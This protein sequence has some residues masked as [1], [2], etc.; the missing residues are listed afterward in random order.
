MRKLLL[1]SAFFAATSLQS[2]ATSRSTTVAF[3]TS[4]N[5]MGKGICS[6]GL[7]N[8]IPA[9]FTY[10]AGSNILTISFNDADLIKYEPGLEPT[11]QDQTSYTFDNAWTAPDVINTSLS[12]AKPI[13]I[14]AGVAYTLTYNGG[15]G[16]R[17]I[18]IDL[19][20]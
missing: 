6:S 18:V 15:N 1:L 9:T 12:V 4:P 11:F 16:T 14:K 5:C 10:D 19:N 20:K 7:D 13:V 2:F 3:G 8:T 17:T